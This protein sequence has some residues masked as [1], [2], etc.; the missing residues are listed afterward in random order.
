MAKI[1]RRF[2]REDGNA[3]IE[4]VVLFPVFIAIFGSAFEAGLFS[5]RQALLERAT[6]VAVRDLR[7]G[8]PGVANFDDLKARICNVA[9]VIP[10]CMGA[11]HIELAPVSTETWDMRLGA[12]ACIDR[13]EDI[14]PVVS[15]TQGGSNELM[16]VRVC[17]VVRPMSPFT[18]LGLKM[19]KINTSDYALVSAA[20]FVNEPS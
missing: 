1:L 10:D 2:G 8:D 13:D 6:D 9:G 15:F 17:A 18:P 5:T 16:L 4:F 20:V 14:T 11:V 19:P 12:T 3:T 7:L